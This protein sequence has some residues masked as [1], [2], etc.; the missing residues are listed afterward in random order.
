M[1]KFNLFDNELIPK[2]EI[3]GEDE[4][5]SVLKRYKIEREQFPKIKI[6]DPVI[7]QI[8]ASVGDVVK[9]TRKSQTAKEALYYRLVIE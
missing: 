6:N 3:L 4:L 5:K 7:Q 9:I 1:N 2:H 8:G